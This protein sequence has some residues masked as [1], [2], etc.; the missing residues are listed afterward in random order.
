[1]SRSSKRRVPMSE[2]RSVEHDAQ[3]TTDRFFKALE[4]G[5]VGGVLNCYTENAQIWHNFDDLVMTPQQ[6]TEQLQV[7][8][9]N[10]AT[11]E[12]LGV[13]RAVLPDGRLLQQHVLRMVRRDGKSIDW[14]GCI[15]LKFAGQKIAR[16]EEYVDMSS[17]LQKLS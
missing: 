4:R 9:E 15:I 6:N 7:F 12:Y 13:R 14:P 8:F 1:M 5:D 11:R 17:F 3:Q 10:F 16:I 2:S